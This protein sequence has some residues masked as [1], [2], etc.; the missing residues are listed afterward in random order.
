MKL[1]IS[2]AKPNPTGKDR[3]PFGSILPFQ[4]AAEWIDITNSDNA[5]INL[6]GLQIYNLSY[7]NGTAQWRIVREFNLGNKCMLPPGKT[8][9]LHSGKEISTNTMRTEDQLGTNYHLF[10]EY[11]NYIWN[12]KQ[13]DRPC[14]FN[15]STKATLD[16]TQYNPPVPDGKILKRYGD[17]LI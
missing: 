9:R 7:T 15:P 4:L 11:N 16:V 17:F 6:N 13:I 10:T 3:P 8:V 1:V 12:N 5:S 2:Q 14:I